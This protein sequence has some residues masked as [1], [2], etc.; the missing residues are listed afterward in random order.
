MIHEGYYELFSTIALGAA[1][2]AEKVLDENKKSNDLKGYAASKKLRDSYLKLKDKVDN[3]KTLE[4]NDWCV[5]L[6]A[7]KLM[8]DGIKG[9][10]KRYQ[11]IANHYE[12]VLLPKLQEVV[13]S[14]NDISEEVFELNI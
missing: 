13:N 14:K 10:I 11:T 2:L 5:L 6:V 8:L 4:K 12:T 3:R 1:N 9:D 7:T